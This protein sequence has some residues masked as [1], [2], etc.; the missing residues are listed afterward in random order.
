MSLKKLMTNSANYNAWVNEQYVNWLSEK[1]EE[2][3]NKEIPS[4]FSS[5][6]KTIDHILGTEKYWYSVIAETTFEPNQEENKTLSKDETLNA[7]L[8]SSKQLLE[9]INSYS[10]EDLVKKVKVVNPWFESD[11]SKY[12]YL[13]H[14]INHGLYHRGQIVTIGRNIG[15]TD[16]PMTDYNFYNVAKQSEQNA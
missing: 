3:L 15:I 6:L 10:E 16:A 14:I 7:F 4:S 8:N 5:I 1:S 12:E 13:Q 2:L 9:L 11:F